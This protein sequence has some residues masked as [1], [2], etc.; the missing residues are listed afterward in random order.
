MP[1]DGHMILQFSTRS[2]F[3]GVKREIQARKFHATLPHKLDSAEEEWHKSQPP[4]VK[5]PIHLDELHIRAPWYED[6]Q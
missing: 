3:E 2:I 4:A 1:H 6:D 5:P